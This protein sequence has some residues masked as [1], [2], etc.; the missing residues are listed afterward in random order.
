MFAVLIATTSAQVTVVT[1]TSTVYDSNHVVGVV[2][3]APGFPVGSLASDGVGKTDMYFTPESLFGHAVTLGDIASISYWTN[4]N[5][6]H[7]ADPRDWFLVIYTKP[8][9]GNPRWYGA[10]IGSEPYFSMNLSETPNAWNQWSTGG[11][12]NTLRFFESTNGYFGAY[13]DPGFATFVSGNS[14]DNVP[15]AGQQILYFSIQTGSAWAAGFTGKVDGLQIKLKDNTQ[16]A[17][18]FEPFLTPADAFQLKYFNTNYGSGNIIL[19]NAGTMSTGQIS[20]DSAGTICANIYSFDPNEEMQACCS[21]PVTPNGLSSMNINEDILAQNL[22]VNPSSAI[23][24]KVLFTLK[25]AQNSGGPCDPTKATVSNLAGGGIAWG[26]NL[27]SVT[28]QGSPVTSVSAVTETTFSRAELSTAELSKL[29]T[30][31]QYVKI[32]GSNVTGICK[33]CQSG[34]RG[35]IGQ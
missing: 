20:D 9:P 5:A 24:V 35:S 31:C 32:L 16:S 19:S 29:A 15:Y 1:P 22:I 33:S 4:K 3:P 25:S 14:L 8:Y 10:R 6:T 30:Y 12:S 28:F 23:T 27:R 18:N 21:C 26:T 7:T 11:P 17:V 34:A 2:D 13:N